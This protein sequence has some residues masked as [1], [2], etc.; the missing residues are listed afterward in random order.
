MNTVSYDNYI[1]EFKIHVPD[2][3]NLCARAVRAYRYTQE[4]RKGDSW[5]TYTQHW[6]DRSKLVYVKVTP[7]NDLREF[8][9]SSLMEWFK[10]LRTRK[11]DPSLQRK[12]IKRIDRADI[13]MIKAV[14]DLINALDHLDE[15]EWILNWTPSAIDLRKK[16]KSNTERN[17]KPRSDK[18][19]EK[20]VKI[21][22]QC[23]NKITHLFKKG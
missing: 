20:G 5:V 17:Q 10:E 2:H 7:L 4:S 23:V 1:I 21:L 18:V 16:V 8:E 6:S 3:E 12:V 15:L 22:S 11:Y 13:C 14:P 19:H 9:S